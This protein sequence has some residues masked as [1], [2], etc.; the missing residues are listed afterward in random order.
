MFVQGQ[1]NQYVRRSQNEKI[2]NAHT[3]Q[4]VKDPQKKMF[5][6][7]FINFG[8]GSLQPVE[9]M[10]HSPH[11]IQV[12]QRKVI[13]EVNRLFPDGSGAFQ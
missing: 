6:G 9:G 12:V 10:M 8:I 11:Y 7:C 1:R 13:P 5:W 3:D 2:C 4:R